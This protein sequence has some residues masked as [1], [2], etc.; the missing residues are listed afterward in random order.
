[1]STGMGYTPQTDVN[2]S[3]VACNCY[4][5]SIISR[6]CSGWCTTH[7]Q[8]KYTRVTPTITHLS[9]DM[10]NTTR[11]PHRTIKDNT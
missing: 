6:L 11:K 10:F 3:M 7:V 4:V 5:H 9:S 2:L 1:M 8:I